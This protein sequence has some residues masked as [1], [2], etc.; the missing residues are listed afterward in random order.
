MRAAVSET[1]AS[2]EDYDDGVHAAEL[3]V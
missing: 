3:Y 2:K 1:E